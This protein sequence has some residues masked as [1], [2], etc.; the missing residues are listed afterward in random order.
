MNSNP[1]VQP[2]YRRL[3]V[4]IN[5]IKQVFQLQPNIDIANGAHIRAIGTVATAMAFQL[6]GS[7][8]E[9]SPDTG[10]DH[11]VENL[12]GAGFRN[13]DDADF[14]LIGFDEIPE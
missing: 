10:A 11:I 1:G 9:E 7:E 12:G 14:D 8:I 3:A 13:G 5:E 2:D 6:H 4:N